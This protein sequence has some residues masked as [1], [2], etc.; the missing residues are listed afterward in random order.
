MIEERLECGIAFVETFCLAGVTPIPSSS[1]LVDAVHRM[2]KAD[3][4]SR[5]W[6]CGLFHGT[7]DHVLSVFKD[8]ES[9]AS[10]RGIVL[11]ETH[12]LAGQMIAL[13]Y[14]NH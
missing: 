5:I 9:S 8:R 14:F 12:F 2:R 4:Y 7:F 13:L 11:G 1:K 6:G 10:C 3:Q